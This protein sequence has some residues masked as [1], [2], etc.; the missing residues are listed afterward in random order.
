MIKCWDVWI[1]LM[2]FVNKVFFKGDCDL[3]Y[4]LVWDY[5]CM[6]LMVVEYFGKL[7]FDELEV[8]LI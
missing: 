6:L 8:C 4:F 2:F 5:E 1:E 7:L 3:V